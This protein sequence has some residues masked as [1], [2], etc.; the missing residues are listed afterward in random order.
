MSTDK[1]TTD[2]NG[3]NQNTTDNK[4]NIIIACIVGVIAIIII[5]FMWSSNKT[6]TVTDVV[7]GEENVTPDIQEI[8]ANDG[9]DTIPMYMAYTENTY[10]EFE[11]EGD[12]AFTA[13]SKQDM[14]ITYM[15]EDTQ[16]RKYTFPNQELVYE[17]VIQYKNGE[18]RLINTAQGVVDSH[19]N[20]LNEAPGM[21]VLLL[22][23][24]LVAG[25]TWE[26][27]SGGVTEIVN[28]DATI[29][30]SMGTFIG[31]EVVSNYPTGG[32]RKEYY[33][34]ALGLVKQVVSNSEEGGETV[35]ELVSYS[36][37]QGLMVPIDVYYVEQEQL[38]NTAVTMQMPF[39]TNVEYIELLNNVLKEKVEG[40]EPLIAENVVI[41]K[42][43]APFNGDTVYIDLSTEF[44]DDMSRRGS[45]E[46]YEMLQGLT[47]TLCRFYNVQ[48]MSLTVNGGKYA[49]GHIELNEG[50]YLYPSY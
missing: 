7:P 19:R 41:N 30:T 20:L 1:N 39:N 26:D 42:L 34:K 23:E 45:G 47:N 44:M 5:A 21:D 3:K 29:E 17:E 4:R 46:E 14:Y 9:T 35:T 16:Q 31:M 37:D 24:P 11:G 50:E 12:E 18:L 8:P 25:N 10:Y 28:M 43:D 6:D 40:Y 2:K 27:G 48:Q 15:N 22:K 32:Y 36:S 13:F 38:L 33:V 49:S